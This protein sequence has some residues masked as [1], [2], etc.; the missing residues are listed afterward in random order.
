MCEHLRARTELVLRVLK[1]EVFLSPGRSR[2]YAVIEQG[3]EIIRFGDRGSPQCGKDAW[4][5][6]WVL[7]KGGRALG[8]TLE[9]GEEVGVQEGGLASAL[10]HVVPQVEKSESF[11]SDTLGKEINY[12]MR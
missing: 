2:R 12:T 9:R 5:R 8:T 7:F 10:S 11:L 3:N 4:S 1:K 6:G